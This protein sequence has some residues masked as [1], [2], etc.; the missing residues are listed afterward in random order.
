MF[1]VDVLKL[2]KGDIFSPFA[3]RYFDPLYSHPD[4]H[5]RLKRGIAFLSIPFI[6][7]CWMLISDRHAFPTSL[8]SLEVVEVCQNLSCLDSTILVPHPCRQ[9]TDTGT[10][11]GSVS[12]PVNQDRVCWPINWGKNWN[13]AWQ[14]LTNLESSLLQSR[15]GS[16]RSRKTEGVRIREGIE[17]KRTTRSRIRDILHD[18]HADEELHI[19]GMVC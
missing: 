13:L 19:R 15:V 2:S 14:P 18:K 16:I 9:D 6:S 10:G 8:L 4:S 11:V 3:I 5:L 12:D 17:L 7:L 1:Y